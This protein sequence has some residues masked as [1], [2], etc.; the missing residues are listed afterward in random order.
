M[1]PLLVSLPLTTACST[2]PQPA[3]PNAVGLH[4]ARASYDPVAPSPA[5]GEVG[6]GDAYGVRVSYS[7]RIAGTHKLWLG[8]EAVAAWIDESE[9]LSTRAEHPSAVS[10]R[11]VAALMRANFFPG[12]DE[13][14]GGG[15]DDLLK[16][17]GLDI[18][19]GIA[20]GRFA[21]G[22]RRIDGL[23]NPAPRADDVFGPTLAVGLKP[24]LS[25]P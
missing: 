9:V 2:L 1:V 25:F 19:A 4:V 14:P 7:R 17:T 12:A 22:P 6:L 5:T 3:G 8:P 21:E 23:P 18:G 20:Y 11:Y 10:R 16:R 15:L 24:D 13:P